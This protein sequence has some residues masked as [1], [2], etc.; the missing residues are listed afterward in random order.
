ML[1]V[2]RGQVRGRVWDRDGSG[3]GGRGR[4]R[5]ENGNGNGNGGRGEGGN[6]YRV[7]GSEGL[8]INLLPTT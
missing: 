8:V 7:L 2:G 3:G 4:D 6:S 1:R 5:D